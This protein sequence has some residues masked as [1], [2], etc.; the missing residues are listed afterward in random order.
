MP[1]DKTAPFDTDWLSAKCL[2]FPVQLSPSPNIN[3]RPAG[4][5]ID[6]LVIHNIS[7][8]PGQFGSSDIEDF[9][10]NR[11]DT[12]KH[13][14]FETLQGLQVS[15]HCLIR[16]SGALIQ[17]A[18]FSARA[19][20]AG[21]S[22]FAGRAECNDFSI[23]IELEGT[24]CKPYTVCQYQSLAA[25]AAYVM[26]QYPAITAERI[27]GHADIAPARKTD[28]GPAFDWRYFWACLDAAK[29]AAS[30]T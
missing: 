9:F 16:R 11:L 12:R 26:V 14:Y 30:N 23:G 27:A 20:H 22:E 3:A 21:R 17:F 19:W 7:L 1:F 13:P 10:L 24:D 28:P 8:P 18:P 15:A 25:V 5:A 2:N 29:Q 4:V 6:L